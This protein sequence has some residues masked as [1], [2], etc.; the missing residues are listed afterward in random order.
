M[1][2][3]SRV[4]DSWED[5]FSDEEKSVPNQGKVLDSWEDEFSDEEKSDEKLKENQPNIT[6]S[7]EEPLSILE[8]STKNMDEEE[9][10]E[11]DNIFNGMSEDKRKQNGIP[12]NF[13]LELESDYEMF[14][15]Y[16]SNILKEKEKEKEKIY[17]FFRSLL[18]NSIKNID[19]K[20]LSEFKTSILVE[21]ND[22][23]K[24]RAKKKGKKFNKKKKAGIKIDNS[25]YNSDMNNDQQAFADF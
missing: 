24:Q 21:M 10:K 7:I 5:E 20:S 11:I 3:Q 16:V 15:V 9:K 1:N 4:L 23:T 8:K 22:R 13:T 14:G 17:K 6:L 25:N 18:D 12:E 19:D 2:S